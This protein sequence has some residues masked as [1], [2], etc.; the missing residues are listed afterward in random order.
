[1]D[2]PAQF[3]QEKRITR[4]LCVRVVLAPRDAPFARR[5]WA[6]SLAA[7]TSSHVPNATNICEVMCC[8]CAA[9]GVILE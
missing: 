5:K 4:G 9:A 8:A 3:S 6:I 2:P 7:T 1:M